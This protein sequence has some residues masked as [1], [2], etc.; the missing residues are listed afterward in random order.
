MFEQRSVAKEPMFE[1]F[2]EGVL[3]VKLRSSSYML[4]FLDLRSLSCF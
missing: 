3:S 2:A 4:E 1:G